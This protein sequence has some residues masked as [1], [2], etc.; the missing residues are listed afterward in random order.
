MAQNSVTLTAKVAGT[1]TVT[2]SD[3]VISDANSSAIETGGSKSQTF[4]VVDPSATTANN[5]NNNNNNNGETTNNTTVKFTD[6]NETVYTTDSCNVRESYSTS[7]NK[8]AKVEKGTQIKRTGVGDNGWSRVEYNGKTCY[9]SSQF[10][11]TEKPADPTF[12]DTN[13]TMYAT[14]SCNVRKSWSTSSDKIGYLNKDQEVTVI[15]VNTEIGWYKIKYN[16]QEAYVSS[17]LLSDEI[18]EEQNEDN[19]NTVSDDE[20][21]ETEEKDELTKLQEEIGVLPEVGKNI[22][23]TFYVVITI[24]ALISI[25]VGYYYINKNANN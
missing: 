21:V 16:E 13:K 18:P 7:S 6:T 3:I 23:T 19:E 25:V 17:R 11:T 1:A 5:N 20:I 22:A 10:L 24:I 12:T 15:G 8:V 14:Q 9:I 2:V 4:T